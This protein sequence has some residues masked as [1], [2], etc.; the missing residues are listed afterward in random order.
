MSKTIQEFVAEREIKV[1][2]HFT[3]ET[4]LASILQ[5]GLVCRDTLV[6]D[7]KA[8]ICNYQLRLDG[9]NAVCASIAF[10]NYKMFWGLRKDNP[11]VEWV[12]LG[13]RPSVL[14][15]T[16][17]AFCSANAASAG[18]TV[19]PLQQRM[20][21]S[22]FQAFLPFLKTAVFEERGSNLPS[23]IFISRQ[24]LA[25]EIIAGSIRG[26]KYF[27]AADLS[28]LLQHVV[29][30]M[31]HVINDSCLDEENIW[32]DALRFFSYDR[33]MQRLSWIVPLL[34]DKSVSVSESHNT[35]VICKRLQLVEALLHELSWRSGSI[36]SQLLSDIESHL[37]HPL[38]QVR[39]AIGD[40]PV[41][42]VLCLLGAP[43]AFK[44]HHTLW[45]R[46]AATPWCH[47][48]CQQNCAGVR[49]P[50]YG[51][52]ENVWDARGIEKKKELF[53]AN[54]VVLGGA[55]FTLG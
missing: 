48:N 1:L 6:S 5:R 7:G 15:E 17:V 20:G 13:I 30:L 53:E 32:S 25:A 9:T 35:I 24:C 29:P 55:A 16:R 11:G 8:N 19:I 36:Q 42:F 45:S 50:F 10:P 26:S 49:C 46:S 23:D 41:N 38:E 22:A 4:N 44:W 39:S 18:V 21:L 12:V 31:R 27:S 47:S 33:H 2:T 14:W 54:D 37:L 3:R 40:V 43:K 34:F 52:G 28:T 51:R